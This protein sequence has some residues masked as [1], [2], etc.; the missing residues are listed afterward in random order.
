MFFAW[1]SGTRRQPV[2][3]LRQRATLRRLRA[4]RSRRA[5]RAPTSPRPTPTARGNIYLAYAE[6]ATVP[7]LPRLA[8]GDQLAGCNQAIGNDP[9]SVAPK[10]NPQAVGLL[11]PA[12]GRPRQRPDDGVPVG[13][14]RRRPRP[15]RRGLL[16]HPD[17]RQ[18]EPGHVQGQL[19]RLRQ[20][21][22]QRAVLER[23]FSQVVATTHPMHYD[24]ICLNG[25]GC[26]L[27]VPA[28]DRTLADFFAIKY[29][30]V[31]HR[32]PGRLQQRREEA[33]ARPPGTSPRP[34]VIT[35]I[36]GPSSAAAR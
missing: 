18:P 16:R 25:L 36:G 12:A 3:L 27:S 2:G 17:R 19:E 31:S 15:G 4:P 30:P 13:R 7:H 29:N 14:R 5:A 22:G 21:V 9:A 20:P 35:Q 34:M 33:R 23:T 10:N 1:T 24:S 26:D 8:A 32:A 11:H 28:G 6:K